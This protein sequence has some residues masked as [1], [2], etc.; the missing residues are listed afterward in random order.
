[1]KT[2]IVAIAV[3]LLLGS[4]AYGGWYVAPARVQAYYPMVP[5]Y[6]Y[7]A[8]V[9]ACS[10]CGLFASGS[11][12]ASLGWSAGRGCPHEGLPSR[13]SYSEYGSGGFALT[14]A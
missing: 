1:M 13:A 8:P 5:A 3:C 10:V 7:P 6:A 12:G 11:A 2:L 14:A 4:T 9:M